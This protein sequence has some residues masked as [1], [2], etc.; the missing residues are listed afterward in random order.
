[1]AT[2]KGVQL[3]ILLTALMALALLGGC[4][5]RPV[6]LRGPLAGANGVNVILFVNKSYRPG[7]EGVLARNL[8]DEFALRS[9]GKVLPGDEAQLELS[10][11]VLSYASQ[12]IS[13]TSND[14]I[15]EYK[16]VVGVQATLRERV[17][18]KVLWKGDLSEEQAYPVNANIALQQNAEEAATA[19]V[20]HRLAERIWQKLGERF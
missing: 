5:Y 11:V 12:P 15:K 4:G 10:G 19:K 1:M 8:V 13:Y 17:T 18:R 2:A 7:V 3:K 20:C 6:T 9:G 16:S 14:T